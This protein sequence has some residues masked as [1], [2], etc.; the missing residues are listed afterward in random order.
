MQAERR[1]R[2]FFAA[3]AASDRIKTSGK[4][5]ERG[6]LLVTFGKAVSTL[7]T[8]LDI[9]NKG[10]LRYQWVTEYRNEH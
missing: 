10:P 7:E 3:K 9:L 1:L 8:D 2:F 6:V 4:G 5:F